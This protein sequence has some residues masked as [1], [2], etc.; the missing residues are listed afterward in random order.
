MLSQVLFSVQGKFEQALEQLLMGNAAEGLRS[1]P[2]TY[3]GVRLTQD[4]HR[5]KIRHPSRCQRTMVDGRTFTTA[6]RQSQSLENAA[7]LTRVA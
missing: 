2:E 3:C 5:Q 6:S 1:R 4:F 7:R